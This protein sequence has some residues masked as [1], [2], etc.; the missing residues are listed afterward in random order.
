MGVEMWQAR[1][2]APQKPQEKRGFSGE[3]ERATSPK[4]WHA[5]ARSL[6]CQL[7]RRQETQREETGVHAHW[8][9]LRSWLKLLKRWPRIAP[10]RQ[11]RDARY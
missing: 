8:C 10:E 1:W 11:D 3:I 9:A 6:S 4:K 7:C 2:H 5:L